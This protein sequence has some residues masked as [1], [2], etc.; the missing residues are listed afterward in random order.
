MSNL[1]ALKRAVRAEDPVL[2]RKA[3]QALKDEGLTDRQCYRVALSADSDITEMW[4]A[5]MLSTAQ[6]LAP[7]L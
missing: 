5:D 3:T 2:I 7:D 6:K 1:A 4:W